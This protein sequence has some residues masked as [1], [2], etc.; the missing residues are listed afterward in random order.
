V[1]L[2]GLLRLVWVM[3]RLGRLIAV[4]RRVGGFGGLRPGG[5]DRSA[6]VST[7]GWP[8]RGTADLRIRGLRRVLHVAVLGTVM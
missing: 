5:R 8:C 2:V 7:A 4:L 1:G 3:L 6:A